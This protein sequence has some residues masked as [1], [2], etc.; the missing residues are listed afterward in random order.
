[1]HANGREIGHEAWGRFVGRRGHWGVVH[2]ASKPGIRQLRT[3]VCNLTRPKPI[4][5]LGHILHI[6]P[7]TNIRVHSR[8]F[9]V[10]I[11][12]LHPRSDWPERRI[13]ICSR[14]T[15]ARHT[16]RAQERAEAYPMRKLTNTFS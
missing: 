14:V 4:A 3:N 2:M 9:A 15:M 8:P 5:L 7:V 16:K 12:F 10:E 11:L 13:R 6:R 1:M